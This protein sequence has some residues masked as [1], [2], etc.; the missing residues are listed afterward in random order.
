MLCFCSSGSSLD[1]SAEVRGPMKSLAL[2]VNENSCG[3]VRRNASGLYNELLVKKGWI[4][5]KWSP[6]ETLGYVRCT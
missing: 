1:M 5:S 6:K 4:A 3:S 2:V